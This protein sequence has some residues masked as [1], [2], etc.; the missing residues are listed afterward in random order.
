MHRARSVAVRR[1]GGIDEQMALQ[2]A[3]GV[4]QRRYFKAQRCVAVV[5]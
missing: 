4:S 2:T 3:L 5:A 1:T